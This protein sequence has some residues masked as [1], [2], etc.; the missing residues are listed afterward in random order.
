MTNGIERLKDLQEQFTE[1][2]EL[3]GYSLYLIEESI[4][5]KLTSIALERLITEMPDVSQILQEAAASARTAA[6]NSESAANAA[7]A[8]VQS[9]INRLAD[10]SEISDAAK[11]AILG[12]LNTAVERSTAA[13]TASGAGVAAADTIDPT[14]TG[15]G[16]V[17]DPMDP[18]D[19]IPA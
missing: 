6:E 16:V 19:V 2:S 8:A 18:E 14:V 15:T 1:I 9:A 7:T 5:L 3:V 10:N 4:K 13:A 17:T 11:S 12:D